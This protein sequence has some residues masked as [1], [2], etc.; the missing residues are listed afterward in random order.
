[1]NKLYRAYLYRNLSND[2]IRMTR[3][4]ARRIP[5]REH[6]LHNVGL[7]SYHPM[8]SAVGGA[9]L[10]AAGGLIGA[11]LVALFS[12]RTG[13]E[14]RSFVKDRAKKF[15]DRARERVAETAQVLQA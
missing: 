8:R 12:P 5:N 11:G 1:M 15:A 2:F 6:W 13:P 7:S 3:R 14:M 9:A 10:F 4:A